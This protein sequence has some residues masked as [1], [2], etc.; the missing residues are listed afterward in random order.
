MTDYAKLAE[1]LNEQIISDAFEER[2][3]ADRGWQIG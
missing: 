1:S 3:I 2:R